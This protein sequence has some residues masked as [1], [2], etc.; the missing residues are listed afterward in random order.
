MFEEKQDYGRHSTKV[1]QLLLTFVCWSECLTESL[2]RGGRFCR[3]RRSFG[4]REVETQL[5]VE[6]V[7]R[8]GAHDVSVWG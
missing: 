2:Q 3:V 7:L 8:A 1:H 4:Y 5:R 6:V